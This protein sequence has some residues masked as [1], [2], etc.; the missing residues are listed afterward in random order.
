MSIYK[1]LPYNLKLHSDIH[2]SQLRSTE[3]PYPYSDNPYPY[4]HN[5]YPYI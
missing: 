1:W 3:Y 2:N 4:S 5:P